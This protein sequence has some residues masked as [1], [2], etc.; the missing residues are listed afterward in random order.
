MPFINPVLIKKMG[1]KRSVLKVLS[2]TL[3]L[4]K[5]LARDC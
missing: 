4:L 2:A 3:L 5:I 1:V